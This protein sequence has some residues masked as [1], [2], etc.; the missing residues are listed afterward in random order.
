MFSYAWLMSEVLYRSL[1]Y[2]EIHVETYVQLGT[3]CIAVQQ[4]YKRQKNEYTSQKRP[5]KTHKRPTRFNN[6]TI[7]RH[8][9]NARLRIDRDNPQILWRKLWRK[10]NIPYA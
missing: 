6:P 1:L 7:T 10:Y 9:P 4:K 8:S 5:N 3:Y 2:I